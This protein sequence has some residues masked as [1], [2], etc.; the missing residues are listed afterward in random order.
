MARKRKD[1]VEFRFYEVPQ[2]EAALVLYGQSWERTY[3]KEQTTLHFHNLLEV[4]I[5]RHGDGVMIYEEDE[6][7]Y[8]DGTITIIPPNYPHVTISDGEIT[9][10]WE[11]LFFDL[12]QIL[13]RL[14]PDNIVF[15][16]K[17]AESIQKKAIITHENMHQG[18]AMAINAAIE[19]AR[20]GRDF[21]KMAGWIYVEALVLEMLREI[22]VEEEESKVKG[23]NMGQIAIAL[24]YI[25][26]NFDKNIKAGDLADL[27]S[28]SETHFRRL[29]ESYINM[30]P[31]DYVNMVRIQKACE[32][33]KKTNY[34]MET[35]AERCGFTTVTTFNRNFK[36]YLGTSPYQWKINPE[37]YE[38]KLQNFRISA[39]R[40][41]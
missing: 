41:W 10:L 39:L 25:S 22:E 33:I 28:L 1:T 6:I 20:R 18:M 34:S 14:F 12:D 32:M 35:V 40:G 37:N 17:A 27:C 8:I 24:D 36:K 4:G 38:N 30:S 16:K 29:F 13:E 9:N 5:C 31:L 19:E 15:R 7:R 2:G 23:S 11:Y 3:G 21:H 26:K